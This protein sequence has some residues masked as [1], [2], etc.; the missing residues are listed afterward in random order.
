MVEVEAVE[1]EA[2]GVEAVGVDCLPR[3]HRSLLG[4]RHR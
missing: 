2:V 3:R 1:V 4:D